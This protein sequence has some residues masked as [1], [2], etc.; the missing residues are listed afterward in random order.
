MQLY[1]LLQVSLGLR[2]EIS[3]NI[4]IEDGLTNG[5][6]FVLK[7]INVHQSTH[8]GILQGSFDDAD[9]GKLTRQENKRL[10]KTG[11]KHSWT[12][13]FK[14][15]RQFNIGKSSQ[16]IRS[17]YPIHPSSAKTMYRAQ[18]D[19]IEP[20]VVDFSGRCHPH[21]HYVACSQVRNSDTLFLNYFNPEKVKI[22]KYVSQ[23]IERLRK[24]TMSQPQLIPPSSAVSFV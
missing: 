7:K 1:T 18:G 4:R 17:Q 3:V 16:V 24:S 8:N 15:S 13:I 19:T 22:E 14:I 9:V 20:L 21:M 5:T 12:P 6:G 10:Y 2:Y 23:E 11:N